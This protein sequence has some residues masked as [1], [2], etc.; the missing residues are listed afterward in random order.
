MDTPYLTA[1]LPGTGGQIKVKN[2]D[3]CVTEIPLYEPSGRGQHTYVQIEKEGLT[4]FRA[5]EQIARALRIDRR[6]VGCA[7]LKDAHAVTVQMLSLGDV[8][9]AA[10]RALDLAGIRILDVSRHTNK[11]KTGHLAGNRF[12]IRIREVPPEATA[13]AQAV[14]DALQR[15]GVPNYFG[16]QRFGLREDTHL[17]GQALVRG[18]LEGLVRRLV[19]MPHPNESARVQHARQAFD[20]GDLAA[21]V[22]LFPRSMGAERR[23]VQ[24]LRQYPGDWERAVRSIPS[25]MRT[26]YG[27]AYQ[28]VLFNR[29]L[30]RRL[31]TLDQLLVGDLANIHGRRSVFLVEDVAAEQPRADRLEISPSGPLY[32]YKLTMA[33]GVPGAME[34]RVLDEE[35]LTL[36]DLR[37]VRLRGARRPLRIPLSGARVWYDEGLMLS[38]ELPPGCYATTVLDEVIKSP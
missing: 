32:G 2:E 21:A 25:D 14:I 29:L 38:F 13:A 37:A 19:G 26:F 10:V 6:T 11:L 15:R 28:S 16:E 18:D 24:I 1:D 31:E 36:E 4:T 9:P 34:Q 22:D 20:D 23:V 8:D 35:G 12:Q 3:F 17:L 5:I 30:A 7:G 27:S 33:Q